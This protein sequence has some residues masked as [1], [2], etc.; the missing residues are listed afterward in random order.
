VADRLGDALGQAAPSVGPVLGASAVGA[1]SLLTGGVALI[2][3]HGVYVYGDSMFG[4]DRS[5]T[6]ALIFI[7]LP[8]YQ[9]VGTAI[10]IVLASVATRRTLP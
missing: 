3:A 8:I 9:W 4:P 6:S 10:L 5:S 2:A 1:C 7:F